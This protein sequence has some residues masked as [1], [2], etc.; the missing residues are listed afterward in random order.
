MIIYALRGTDKGHGFSEYSEN[1]VAHFSD[2]GDACWVRDHIDRIKFDIIRTG[3]YR[4]GERTA[5]IESEL[6]RLNLRNT[7]SKHDFIYHRYEIDVIEVVDRLP[8][9]KALQD[10]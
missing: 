9:A 8:A 7:I 10:Q 4:L 3:K 2:Y 6:D 5:Y 1:V